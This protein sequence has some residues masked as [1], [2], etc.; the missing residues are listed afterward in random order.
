M[1][2][3]GSIGIALLWLAGCAPVEKMTAPAPQ[4]AAPSNTAVQEKSV[5]RQAI[6]GFT[7]KTAVDAG[8]RTKAKIMDIN[9]QRRSNFKE[10]PP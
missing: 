5:A 6:E 9:E 4:P 7:G 10:I 3:I 2:R 8:Q 1:K